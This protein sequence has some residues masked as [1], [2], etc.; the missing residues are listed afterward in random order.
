[1]GSFKRFGRNRIVLKSSVSETESNTRLKALPVLISVVALI[2]S[3][4][5]WCDAHRGR[6]INEEVN[7]PILTVVS[8]QPDGEISNSEF[9]DIYMRVRLRNSGRVTAGVN[10][11]AMLPALMHSSGVCMFEFLNI[12]DGIS[13]TIEKVDIAPG[14]EEVLSRRF[15]VLKSCKMMRFQA[16]VSVG[17]LDPSGKEFDQAFTVPVL[18]SMDDLI[19]QNTDTFTTPTA[20]P[21]GPG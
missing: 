13:N 1:M 2:I 9:I 17:Y 14:T 21:S 4:F 11:L 15:S 5:G 20:T 3:F 8:I 19:K 12:K 18:I 7:R 10:R 6:L 16:D